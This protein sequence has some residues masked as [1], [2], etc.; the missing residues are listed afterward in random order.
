MPITAIS[1]RQNGIFRWAEAKSFHASFVRQTSSFA[2][3]GSAT[4][5]CEEKMMLKYSLYFRLLLQS[6]SSARIWPHLEVLVLHSLLRYAAPAIQTK[7]VPAMPKRK[8]GTGFLA[9][10]TKEYDA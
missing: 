5:N 2:R 1:H 3:A 9:A 8:S 7:S 10:E 4:A 6:V